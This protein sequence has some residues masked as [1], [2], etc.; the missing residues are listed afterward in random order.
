MTVVSGPAGA[1]KTVACASWAAATPAAR[2]VAWLTLD[3]GRPRPGP[4]L[5]YVRA[6]LARAGAVP[7]DVA[8]VLQDVPP[9]A[10]PLRV[11]EAAQLLT[12]P[13]TLVLDDVHELA[14]GP[15]LAGLD[16]LIRHAPPTL[17]LILSGRCPPRLALA[18]L[19]VCR[20][21]GRREHGRP[22]LHGR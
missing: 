14:D 7:A 20:R 1:G 6:A 2:R 9:D 5:A 13:V 12:E 21:A 22:G 17:R 15:V 11:V 3:A 10:F 18:R 4:V 19:R 8:R 16:L